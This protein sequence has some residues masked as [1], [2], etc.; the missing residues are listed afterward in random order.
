MFKPEG[1]DPSAF[2]EKTDI[3]G[4]WGDLPEDHLDDVEAEVKEL[5][6][7]EEEEDFK[8]AA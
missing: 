3:D 4:A 5:E 8:M 7:I 2:A 6:A 1:F